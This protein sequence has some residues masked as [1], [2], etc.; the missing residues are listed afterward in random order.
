MSPI[1]SLRLRSEHFGR[2]PHHTEGIRVRVAI[3]LS[4][5]HLR[6]GDR[7]LVRS[8]VGLLTGTAN[9]SSTE[10]NAIKFGRSRHMAGFPSAGCNCRH[11]SD[12]PP[13]ARPARWPTH[14]A[15]ARPAHRRSPGCRCR[16]HLIAA[17]DG[18]DRRSAM[19][20][21]QGGQPKRLSTGRIPV[22]DV[23]QRCVCRAGTG[24]RRAATG[25]RTDRYGA[26][27]P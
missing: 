14:L 13:R 23:P 5:A 1:T 3:R 15:S 26:S 9:S 25:A 7:Q 6:S 12:A 20:L 8:I 21:P 2:R 27:E 19:P 24:S 11:G 18:T 22:S 16:R 4:V 17:E 10:R